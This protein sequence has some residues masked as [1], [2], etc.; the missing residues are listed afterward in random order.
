MSFRCIVTIYVRKQPI[1]AI[2]FEFENEL[3]F[4]SLKAWSQRKGTRWHECQLETQSSL[5]IL[6]FGSELDGRY[7]SCKGLNIS[8]GLISRTDKVELIATEF[9]LQS[10]DCLGYLEQHTKSCKSYLV[11]K[12]IYLRLKNDHFYA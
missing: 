11:G 7:M 12:Y 1:I 8:H 2:Y 3:E 6:A 10:C 9:S 5:F 4:Y